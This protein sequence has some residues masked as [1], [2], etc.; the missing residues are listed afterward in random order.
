MKRKQSNMKGLWN[1]SCPQ[2]AHPLQEFA[3][4]IAEARQAVVD[5]G[6]Q[7]QLVKISENDVVGLLDSHAKVL[8]NEDSMELAADNGF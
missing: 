5:I 8:T 7:V 2:F 4:D 3:D 1:K 6:T